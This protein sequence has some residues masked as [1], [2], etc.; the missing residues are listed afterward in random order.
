MRSATAVGARSAGAHDLRGTVEP[1]RLADL[2][3]FDED[4]LRDIKHLRTVH[5]T[6]KR[7]RRHAR[8]DFEAG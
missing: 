8:A 3:V 6:V 2:A 4:P 5:L 1:G 7:G